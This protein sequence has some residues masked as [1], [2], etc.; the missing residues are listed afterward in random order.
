MRYLRTQSQKLRRNYVPEPPSLPFPRSTLTNETVDTH[1]KIFIIDLY[2]KQI[3]FLE[4]KISAI[5][6]WKSK[7]GRAKSM[8]TKGSPYGPHQPQQQELGSDKRSLARRTKTC[9]V[10]S[11]KRVEASSES[12]PLYWNVYKSKPPQLL[13][14]P[15]PWASLSST[16]S[17]NSHS[18]SREMSASISN[19][20]AM[21][22]ATKSKA[23]RS[24]SN[25]SPSPTSIIESHRKVSYVRT[26]AFNYSAS[27][28]Y[29]YFSRAI[30]TCTS[31]L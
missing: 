6:S 15:S 25:V 31:F 5:N 12:S 20:G 19:N 1:V 3:M 17:S 10:Q 2:M 8:D 16:L 28:S 4:K 11:R 24:A 9:S 21:G 18:N 30:C 26:L 14:T 29:I 22:S 23:G 27:Q 7:N 13:H